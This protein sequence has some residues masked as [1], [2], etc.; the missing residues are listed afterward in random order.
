MSG[1]WSWPRVPSRIGVRGEA[2]GSPGT[3]AGRATPGQLEAGPLSRTLRVQGGDHRAL[4]QAGRRVGLH[5]REP[6]AYPEA[7][8][9]SQASSVPVPD[10]AGAPAERPLLWLRYDHFAVLCEL[11]PVAIPSLAVCLQ[12]L[13]HGKALLPRRRGWPWPSSGAPH[14]P[15]RHPSP[16]PRQARKLGERVPGHSEP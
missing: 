16:N 4:S 15:P 14:P 7:A 2:T 11:L 12:S 5:T 13:L 10:G 8:A 3:R 6:R 9:S 1:P